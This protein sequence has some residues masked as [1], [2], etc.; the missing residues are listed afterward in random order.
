M[1]RLSEQTRTDHDT[2][3]HAMTKTAPIE[4]DDLA[5]RLWWTLFGAVLLTWGFMIKPV[6]PHD[7]WGAV[8]GLLATAWGLGTVVVAWLPRR[9][10]PAAALLG[11]VFAWATALIAF[12]AF[13]VWALEQLHAGSGYGTDELA[14]NQLAGQLARHGANPYTHSMR[15]AFPEFRVSPGGY[16]YTLTGRKV[17]QL[18][19]PAL[20]FLVYVPFLALGWANQL[21]PMLDVIGLG[22]STLLIFHLLPRP[23]RVFALVLGSIGVYASLAVIGLTDMVF[24]PLLVIAAYRWNRFDA[25]SWRSYVGPVAFG[26]AMAMKQT[27]WPIL[28][29]LVVG[30]LIEEHDR[31][32]LRAGLRRAGAYL[33]AAVGA[34]LIPN[35]PY[36]VAAP[37][38][39]VHGT[40]TPFV[41]NL[42]PAGQGAI[43]LSLVLRL[44]GGSLS[45]YT[46]L[47]LL[48]LVLLLVAYCASY[49]VLRPVT[50]FLP[51]IAYFFAGR[52]YAVYLVA[53]IPPAVVGAMTLDSPGVWPRTAGSGHASGRSS[54]SPPPG[55]PPPGSPPPIWATWARSR[56]WAIATAGVGLL[57]VVCFIFVLAS[58]QPLSLRVTGVG[59]SPPN[60]L[61][62]AMTVLVTNRSSSTA[63]PAFTLQTDAGVTS[64]WHIVSGPRRLGPG[65][66]ATYA[67]QSPNIPSELTLNQGITVLAL[68]PHPA[69][70]SV[71]PAYA[72]PTWHGGFT[73]ESIDSLVP[74]GRTVSFRVQLLNSW[75][76][77]IRRANVPVTVSQSLRGKFAI[78]E[79]N[80]GRAGAPATADT[81]ANGV[82]SFQIVGMTASPF[83]LT[84]S[85]TVP[86]GGL[87]GYK[88]LG[89]PSLL[90]R[91]KDR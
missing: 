79:L 90:V 59:T 27:P 52:S 62:E 45:A 65:R 71:S 21:S 87:L 37:S 43:G 22:I 49:P 30:L 5:P 53:L 41:S 16:T 14:F 82:A 17:T 55:S 63:T 78:A 84:L 20:S 28:P 66:T 86:D 12:A 42:V 85:T 39:W 81:N 1:P 13:I 75:D 50:F 6:A 70:V 91:F 80:G 19:Y 33:G 3:S 24:M 34:F 26:L 54:G 10:T 57:C 60:N 88:A 36:M 35:L 9:S 15:A 73:P 11:E 23:H 38:A 47:S 83:G 76:E 68:L 51:A 69:S 7:D 32:G 40:L 67:L 56:D 29:F 74:V 89:G 72:P 64:F 18:S 4:R 31:A 46:V 25:H 77:P 44:G 2:L 58:K 61:V 8:I 48:V